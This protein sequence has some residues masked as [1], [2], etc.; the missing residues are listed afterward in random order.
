[1]SIILLQ[2]QIQTAD[3]GG[4]DPGLRLFDIHERIDRPGT[5]FQAADLYTR[6]RGFCTADPAMAAG[7]PVWRIL[8]PALSETDVQSAERLYG[9]LAGCGSWIGLAVRAYAGSVYYLGIHGNGRS[10][11]AQ[12]G[13]ESEGGV[14]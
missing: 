13:T 7:M 4:K 10:L 9:R 5:G 1:M 3:A 2:L 14:I 12:P 8:L 11:S 6:I